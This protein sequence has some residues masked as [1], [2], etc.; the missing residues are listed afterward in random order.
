MRNKEVDSKELEKI[1][2]EM[3]HEVSDHQFCIFCLASE[4]DIKS[5]LHTD[6]VESKYCS[7]GVCEHCQITE[8]ESGKFRLTK[9]DR[10]YIS[11]MEAK[12]E[13]YKRKRINQL[14]LQI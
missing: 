2:M 11:F 4:I 6:F 1:I 10:E 5:C 13:E 12:L 3:G 8:E 14:F 7:D 9:E